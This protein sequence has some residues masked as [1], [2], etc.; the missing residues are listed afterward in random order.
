M[1]LVIDDDSSRLMQDIVTGAGFPV[2][3]VDT[4]EHALEAMANETYAV[5]LLD[6]KPGS[7]GDEFL[8]QYRERSP[9]TDV[10]VVTGYPSVDDAVL[11]LNGG[12]QAKA[13]A[14]LEKPLHG[15][16][17]VELVE[18]LASYVQT[19]SWRIDRIRKLAYYNDTEFV[20]PPQLFNLFEY[21]LR[22]PNQR[23]DYPHLA[24][25]LT[26]QQMDRNEAKAMLKTQM[27]RLRNTL[28]DVSGTKDVIDTVP[29]EGFCLAISPRLA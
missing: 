13:V 22:F 20:L 1:I 21:F 24:K 12:C 28:D 19:G 25:M 15:R 6:M 17:V 9:F 26:G 18:R 10:I 5:V 23:F 8:R 7:G 29:V 16:E 27:W 14:Y 4:A 11:A 3:A 2:H